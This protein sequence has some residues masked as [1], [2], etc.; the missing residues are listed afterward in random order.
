MSEPTAPLAHRLETVR[1]S[2]DEA[3]ME[4]SRGGRERRAWRWLER[5]ATAV[6]IAGAVAAAGSVVTGQA[7]VLHQTLTVRAPFMVVDREK[8]PVLRITAEGFVPP[9]PGQ[10][11]PTQ[12]S[13]TGVAVLSKAGLVAA[14]IAVDDK[15]G[16]QINIRTGLAGENRLIAILALKS[17]AGGLYGLTDKGKLYAEVGESGYTLYHRE[18]GNALGQLGHTTEGGSIVIANQDG[19]ALLKG[20]VTTNNEG[21]VGVY[22][23]GGPQPVRIPSLLQGR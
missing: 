2:L 1:Q 21:L 6:T 13:K 4:I 9:Q 17:A 10:P 22:P 12:V 19:A 16:G 11:P 20:I 3:R 14:S 18:T 8:H 5:A 15:G 7:H 23:I